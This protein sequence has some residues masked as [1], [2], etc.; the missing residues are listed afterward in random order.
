[1]PTSTEWN[2]FEEHFDTRK[3]EL[4]TCGQ[5]YASD[6]RHEHACIRCP[7]LRMNPQ[8]A[9]RLQE[10]ETDLTWLGEIEGIDLT[11]SLLRQKQ[12][13]AARLTSVPRTVDLGIPV[14]APRR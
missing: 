9:F 14:V 3:V 6:C 11:L 5:P 7:V 10:I 12:I 13:E 1:M 8:M 2:E 4:G